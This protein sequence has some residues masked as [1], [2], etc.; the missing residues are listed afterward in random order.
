MEIKPSVRIKT[1]RSF[2][3]EYQEPLAFAF[4]KAFCQILV[5]NWPDPP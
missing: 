4:G 3:T 5:S 1:H 2:L